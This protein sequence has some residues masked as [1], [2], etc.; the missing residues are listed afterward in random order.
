MSVNTKEVRGC[1]DTCQKVMPASVSFSGAL[2]ELPDGRDGH[3]LL[4][5]ISPKTPDVELLTGGDRLD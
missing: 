2:S 1:C 3:V 5:V 4:S